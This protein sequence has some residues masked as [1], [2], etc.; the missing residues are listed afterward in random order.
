MLLVYLAIFVLF[1]LMSAFFSSAETSLLSLDKIKLSNNVRKKDRK[2][3]ILKRILEAPDEFFSTILIGNNIVNIGA[4]S[5]SAILVDRYLVQD[6]ELTLLYSTAITTI[7]ILVF[8]E[9]IPKSYAFRYSSKLASLYAYPIRFFNYLFYPLV[10][11]FSFLSGMIFDNLR[12]E[13]KEITLDELRNY[14]NSEVKSLKYHPETLNMVNSILEIAGRDIRTVMVPRMS[15]KAI[16]SDASMEELYDLFTESDVESVPVYKDS[17]DHI[18]GVV[19][20]KKVFKKL[21]ENRQ[22][23]KGKVTDVVAEPL[24]VTEYTS[25]N[26][27]IQELRR[28]NRELAVVLDEYGC[29]AGVVT[30]EDIVGDMAGNIELG[31]P[32]IRQVDKAGFLLRGRVPVDQISR[33]IGIELTEKKDYTTISGYLIYH[34][35]KFPTKGARIEKDGI[36]FEVRDMGERKIELV[37]LR[38]L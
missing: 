33:D 38:R 19:D 3:G 20:R 2:A 35:G 11:F 10:K 37:H 18:T 4:A 22:F 36:L 27:V 34:F 13:D 32:D 23:M 12:D 16:K 9:I 8:S 17:M 29:T 26:Y 1:V 14:L 25:L 15:V 21:L 6:E 7:I 24:K 30:L 28:S 31:S 5:I